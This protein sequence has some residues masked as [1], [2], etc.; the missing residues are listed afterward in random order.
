MDEINSLLYVEINVLTNSILLSAEFCILS[1]HFSESNNNLR[2]II[3]TVSLII[4][5]AMTIIAICLSSQNVMNSMESMIKET[6]RR[7]AF[8]NK[9]SS[10]YF[11]KAKLIL[12]MRKEIK[13]SASTLF[14]LKSTTLLLIVSYVANYAVILIQT[15]GNNLI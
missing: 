9:L 2:A 1:D 8:T 15:S 6:K 11:E 10:D 13:F 3:A 4:C 7:I 12:S 14:A 5:S